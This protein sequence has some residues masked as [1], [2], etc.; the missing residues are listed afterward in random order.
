[1]PEHDVVAVSETGHG[2]PRG[3]NARHMRAMLNAKL[4]Q[5]DPAEQ[6]LRMLASSGY[7]KKMN[8]KNKSNLC[9]PLAA[10]S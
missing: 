2:F 9:L 5:L 1:M 7:R 10:K 3:F 4:E 6:R 8:R